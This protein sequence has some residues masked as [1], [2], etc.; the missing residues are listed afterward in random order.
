MKNSCWGVGLLFCFGWLS[1]LPKNLPKFYWHAQSEKHHKWVVNMQMGFVAGFYSKTANCDVLILNS[2]W[3]RP[4]LTENPNAERET[5]LK[6]G[7]L[8]LPQ[9]WTCVVA[10]VSP[11]QDRKSAGFETETLMIC[12]SR[13]GTPLA[14]KKQM[15]PKMDQFIPKGTPRWA[16]TPQERE[17]L[18]A[19]PQRTLRNTKREPRWLLGPLN[20]WKDV[21]RTL[22]KENRTW[23]A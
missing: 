5:S 10:K 20:I 14:Q 12:K 19:Q 6:S 13:A 9:L 3:Q 17:N 8:F 21:T 7:A 23:K 1:M 15:E 16:G 11:S 18:A 2:I 4:Y 22:W